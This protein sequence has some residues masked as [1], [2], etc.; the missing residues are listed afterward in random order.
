M[1]AMRRL[2]L[3]AVVLGA[4]VLAFAGGLAVAAPRRLP[5]V[6]LG[7]VLLWRV[8]VAAA[9]FVVAYVA[10]VAVHLSLH[11]RTFTRVGSTGIEIPDMRRA[12][13]EETDVAAIDLGVSLAALRVTT[14]ALDERLRTLE[15]PPDVVLR[16]PPGDL[17]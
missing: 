3:P 11:G 2:L 10:V 1:T 8:E 13:E 14:E 12:A 9:S 17:A 6:A 5:A 7:A 15:H 4:L 16:S